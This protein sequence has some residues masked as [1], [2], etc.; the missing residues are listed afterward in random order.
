MVTDLAQK[1]V[2]PRKRD[3]VASA[4]RELG[5]TADG[6]WGPVSQQAFDSASS[7]VRTRIL[8][9]LSAAN[10][11]PA[12][13][14]AYRADGGDESKEKIKNLIRSEAQAAGVDA[15][16]LLAKASIE[17][18]F[19]P[20]R[21]NGSSR[22][23]FQFQPAAWTDA[24]KIDPRIGD[25]SNVYDAQANTRAAIA[26]RTVL[27]Q[28]LRRL[29]YQ[30]PMDNA[31]LYIAHQ[32]GAGGLNELFR[33]SQGL[34]PVKRELVT[35]AAMTKNPPQDGRGVTTDKPTFYKRWIA[36]GERVMS[37]RI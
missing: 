32:Q 10:L 36:V 33:A 13:M 18:N 2:A 9:I 7:T 3:V 6:R 26:Y 28:T 4:Q 20:T 30:G 23:L 16:Y 19:G 22:G 5:V 8:E 14:M 21:S 27:E 25:Y 12:A 15:Q 31:H 37:R 17:S 34:G 24:A 1:L 35:A 29:R 11:T